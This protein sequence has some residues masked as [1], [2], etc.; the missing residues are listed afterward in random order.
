MLEGPELVSNTYL[1]EFLAQLQQEGYD[2]FLVTGD[3]PPCDA[4]LVLQA[5]PAVQAEPPRLL[6]DV[7]TSGAGAGQAGRTRAR[8]AGRDEEADLE[9]AMMLSLAETSGP[10]GAPANIDSDQ[11]AR[12]MEM[13]RQGNWETNTATEDEMMARALRMSEE[14]QQQ[15]YQHS[16]PSEE[17]EIQAAIALS[18]EGGAGRTGGQPGVSQGGA[19]WGS[20]LR[21]QEVEEEEKWLEEQERARREEEEQ[22]R[23]ALMMSMETESAPAGSKKEEKVKAPAEV[24]PAHTAWPKMKNPQ[25]GSLAAGGPSTSSPSPRATAT[26]ST[27][28]SAPRTNPAPAPSS[29]RV[30]APAI[31]EGE[32]HRLGEA[33]G[34]GRGAAQ[35]RVEDPQEIR[36][37]RMAFLDKLQKSPPSENK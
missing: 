16:G 8:P 13:Q 32:G 17:D 29:S 26:A 22:L 23:Q 15:S 33:G 6:S 3:L 1:G 4:D 10:D 21:E 36:R 20:R 34:G 37:R 5:V 30:A 12:V 27:S 24:D 7:T 31:P 25:P 14:E 35:P 2:I 19:G 9:A 18:L 28:T 11:L